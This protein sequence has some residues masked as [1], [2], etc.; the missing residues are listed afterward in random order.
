MSVPKAEPLPCRQDCSKTVS[1]SPGDSVAMRESFGWGQRGPVSSELLHLHPGIVETRPLA[2]IRIGVR[3]QGVAG[4]ARVR[5]AV[6]HP[7]G[8]QHDARLKVR[9]E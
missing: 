8:K 4:V 5:V 6:P 9:I 3:R 1:E 7:L 2:E